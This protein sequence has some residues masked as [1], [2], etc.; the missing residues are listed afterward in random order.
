MFLLVPVSDL[1]LVLVLISASKPPMWNG[2]LQ[3]LPFLSILV[4]LFQPP[5]PFWIFPLLIRS[6]VLFEDE[7]VL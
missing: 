5:V 6:F 7:L 1:V 3:P 4:S 2:S